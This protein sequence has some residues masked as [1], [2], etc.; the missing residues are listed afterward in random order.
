M[1]AQWD[2]PEIKASFL[3]EA[4]KPG[5]R[6]FLIY[7]SLLAFK[8]AMPEAGLRLLRLIITAL[9]FQE[10]LIGRSNEPKFYGSVTGF[11]AQFCSNK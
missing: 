6:R 7:F 1:S 5:G 11:Y 8:L 3:S 10:V 4:S 9:L 2:F